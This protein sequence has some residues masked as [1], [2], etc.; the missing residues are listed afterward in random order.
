MKKFY[1]GMKVTGMQK[2]TA[3]P[4]DGRA[5]YRSASPQHLRR[6]GRKGR[7]M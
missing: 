5:N 4:K 7:R 6:K 3:E 1:P 2:R